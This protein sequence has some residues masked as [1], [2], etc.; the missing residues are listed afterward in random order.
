MRRE[1]DVQKMF[2]TPGKQYTTM[3]PSVI[4]YNLVI[5]LTEKAFQNRLIRSQKRITEQTNGKEPT[6]ICIFKTFAKV[7]LI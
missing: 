4:R 7:S 6:C 1:T 3:D 2:T 5:S